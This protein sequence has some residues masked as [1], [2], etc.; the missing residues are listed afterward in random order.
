MN[1][2]N[3][4]RNLQ[5]PRNPPYQRTRD[6]DDNIHE[7]TLRRIGSLMNENQSSATNYVTSSEFRNTID[8]IQALLQPVDNTRNHFPTTTLPISHHRL[9]T[10][11]TPPFNQ[12]VNVDIFH[13]VHNQPITNYP[14]SCGG[15]EGQGD[16]KKSGENQ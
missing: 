6:N 1:P 2:E 16:L 11:R 7:D 9:P 3:T 5:Y 8:R 12:E 13:N 14:P 15:V 10:P 4:N